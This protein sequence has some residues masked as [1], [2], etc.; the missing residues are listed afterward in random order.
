MHLS[1]SNAR[2][3]WTKRNAHWNVPIIRTDLNNTKS[4]S[5]CCCCC[6][7]CWRQQTT[8]NWQERNTA[9]L[10]RLLFWRKLEANWH[11]CKLTIFWTN[12]SSLDPYCSSRTHIQ[13]SI[14]R[15]LQQ[16]K[17]TLY[18]LLSCSGL[19]ALISL[20]FPAPALTS[21]A[22]L[23]VDPAVLNRFMFWTIAW[24]TVAAV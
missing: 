9:L 19:L 21:L 12:W 11:V 7:C 16:H 3:H 13:H 1:V 18:F 2:I 22:W 14:A 6:Y 17:V 4:T 10:N 23:I 24:L 8:W 15:V 20:G 5:C